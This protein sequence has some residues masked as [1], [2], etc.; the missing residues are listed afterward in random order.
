MD[1]VR[2]I[3]DY[4]FKTS[5]KYQ[6]ALAVLIPVLIPAI[7]TRVVYRKARISKGKKIHHSKIAIL[8]VYG[9]LLVGTIFQVYNT[10]YIDVGLTV[11]SWNVPENVIVL[12]KSRL[13]TS[14]E[15][16]GQRLKNINNRGS[17][18]GDNLLISRL[19]S[20]TGRSLYALYGDAFASCEWCRTD[21]NNSFLLYS[22]PSTL[23][24]YLVNGGI[25]LLC[26]TMR[27]LKPLRRI[28]ILLLSCGALYDIYHT[29]VY[30][31]AINEAAHYADVDWVYWRK[32]QLRGMLL[33]SFN[34]MS[35]VLFYLSLK[36]FLYT[37]DDSIED[38]LADLNRSLDR[39]LGLAKG[40]ILIRTTVNG[41]KELTNTHNRFWDRRYARQQSVQQIAEVTEAKENALRERINIK[42]V[43][44]DAANFVN[45]FI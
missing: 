18:P 20:Q 41:D 39:A 4:F 25:I 1:Q 32:L 36:G 22:I 7:Y 3:F 28:L 2:E 29:A 9:L 19:S 6:N 11:Y 38:N 40:S 35:L 31:V 42:V 23:I 16:I 43:Q 10:G 34:I 45:T 13:Q 30:P 8:V 14:G 5:S 44:K 17:R 24:P 26:T 12:T 33:A 21:N 15:V 37:I 27:N